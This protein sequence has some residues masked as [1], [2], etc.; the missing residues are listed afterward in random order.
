MKLAMLLTRLM[1]NASRA[2]GTTALVE[3]RLKN[4]RPIRKQK[5][6]SC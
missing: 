4:C 3:E 5:R 1:L 6:R 2:F